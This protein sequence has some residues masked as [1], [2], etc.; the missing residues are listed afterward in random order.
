MLVG[1]GLTALIQSSNAMCV[2]VV[3]FVNA[4]LMELERS[5]G[6]LM[7][8]KIGT[9]ITG[10][11]IA[12]KITTVAPVIAFIGVA[13]TMFTK[14][15][16]PRAVGQVIAS[17]GILFIGLGNMS[18]AME[19]LG[20]ME[21]FRNLLAS[22]S[23][24]I[25]CILVGVIFTVIVQSAS[26][27]VGVL[28]I[29]VLNQVIGFEQ[30]FF[31]MMGMNIG[32]SIA[33]AIASLGGRKDA[34][35]VAFIVVLFESI[36]MLIFLVLSQVT[37]I[38][39]WIASTSP[40]LS[41]QIANANTIFNIVTVVVLLPFAKYLAKIATIVIP[42]EDESKTNVLQNINEAGYR[43]ASIL[44]EQVEAEVRRM[45]DVVRENLSIATDTYRTRAIADMEEFSEREE[46]IDFLNK[47]ITDTLVRMNSMDMTASEAKRAGN[48]FHVVSDLERIGDQSEELVS[49]ANQMI[50]EKEQFSIAAQQELENL[51]Q[52]IYELY[53]K[54]CKHLF[55]PEQSR[56]NDIYIL[57]RQITS[58]IDDMKTQHIIRL[59][60]MVCNSTQGL[61]FIETLT[62]LEHVAG[63][64]LSIARGSKIRYHHTVEAEGYTV[65][66]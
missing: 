2:M 52:M 66:K 15:Q 18:D 41:R 24:P 43:D 1:A 42:G 46:T 39:T 64:T 44:V 27:S 13:V 10:Q 28:Q 58:I 59:N 16:K 33:P 49:Y 60:D 38:L 19:P 20:Q 22:F 36:G 45:V 34:K 50:E 30:G 54:A 56:Y 40:N 48:L 12:F 37:P 14:K 11:L 32:A 53:D 26:A 55:N 3:G 8:A 47:A 57:N 23:N 7:G 25:L 61:Y 65:T 62:N 63:H 31:V 35:R 51:L 21:W 6:I 5:V 29:M 17:L 4:G 9:T